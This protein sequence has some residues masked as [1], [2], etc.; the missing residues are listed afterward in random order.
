MS[1]E[2][3]DY[4]ITEHVV[5]PAKRNKKKFKY[6]KDCFNPQKDLREFLNRNNPVMHR[7]SDMRS[8]TY[9]VN[10]ASKRRTAQ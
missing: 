6:R 3:Q 1:E 9:T 4:R 10:S 8:D 5:K 2:Y 7:P